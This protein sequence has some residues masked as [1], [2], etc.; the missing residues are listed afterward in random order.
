MKKKCMSQCKLPFS[1]FAPMAT[2]S[3]P[4][5][6]RNIMKGFKF[7]DIFALTLA[8]RKENPSQ[9]KCDLQTLKRYFMILENMS[10]LL[11]IKFC[12]NMLGLGCSFIENVNLECLFPVSSWR[13]L[14]GSCSKQNKINFK[15]QHYM[16]WV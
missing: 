2:H 14:N 10:T 9:K 15:S 13:N 16:F 4:I 7:C 1:A 6:P 11:S 3:L 5:I 8:G 12:F